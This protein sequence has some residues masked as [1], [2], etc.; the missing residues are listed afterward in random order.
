MA[1]D[2]GATG[3]RDTYHCTIVNPFSLQ[4]EGP[5]D[6]APQECSLTYDWNSDTILSG[7]VAELNSDFRVDGYDK[8][9]RIY[10]HIECDGAVIDEV[11][12][13]MFV[14]DLTRSSKYGLNKRSMNMRSTLWRLSQDFLDNDFARDTGD[15]CISAISSLITSVGGLVSV[16]H[17]AP[18]SRTFG[19]PIWFPMG[20]NRLE[21]INTMCGWIGAR[22]GIDPYGYVTIS[23]YRDPY[24]VSPSSIYTFE[25]GENCLYLSG[26]EWEATRS[27]PLNRVVAYF[28]RENKPSDEDPSIP[29]SARYV[30]NLP[31][32]S[33]FSFVR[34][35]R[36]R[37]EVLNVDPCT[38]EELAASAELYL[39]ENS[40]DVTSIHIQHPS[41]PGLGVG[42][43]VYYK[44]STDDTDP[45]SVRCLIEEQS[46]GSLGP[47]C[48]VNSKLK[49]LNWYSAPLQGVSPS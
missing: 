1:V 13:T 17:D 15:N 14:D 7:S 44:N 35:G 42:S 31:E 24:Q 25:D 23:K 37:T 47:G 18:K 34:S 32:H 6:I 39:A 26:I 33:Q 45:V 48:L 19:N 21:T 29:L 4:D 16:S 2:W 40:G 9:V 10:H 30:A 8:L 12:G 11:L 27:D 22:I 49:I 3:R 5:L 46:I 28:S 41:I 38:E 36:Y 43:V 20:E